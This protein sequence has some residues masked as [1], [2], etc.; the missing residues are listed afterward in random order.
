MLG[1]YP[2]LAEPAQ[3]AEGWEPPPAPVVPDGCGC[4][5][6]LIETEGRPV[7][8]R[9][10]CFRTPTS[11]RQRDF[12]GHTQHALS[13]DGDAVLVDLSAHEI[14]EVELRFD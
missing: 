8:V 9:L 10:R 13:I 14:A 11:A 3:P 1:L 5:V 2:L 12:T 6:R 7:R 4:G